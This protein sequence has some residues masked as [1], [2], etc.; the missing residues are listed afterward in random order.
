[1]RRAV[2]PPQGEGFL[3]RWSRLKREPEPAPQVVEPPAPAEPALPEGKTLEDLI[4]ELPKVEDLVPGQSVAAF[5]QPWVPT[6]LRNAALQRMWL[7]DPAIRDY[8]S[9]ALDYAYDYNTPG[10]APGFGQIE[11]TKD[12][13]REVA[14]LFDRALA[15]KE[16]A[17]DPQP[18]NDIV[19]QAEGP[20]H[21]ALQHE[22]AAAA[23]TDAPQTRNSAAE[24][25]QSVG[26]ADTAPA[27]AHNN[28]RFDKH[29]APS[30][31]R[32]GG[33]LPA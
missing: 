29:L 3:S 8:V 13:V 26:S 28:S 24:A 11:T 19:S 22:D 9:P 17:D 18:G 6:P 10:A 25:E 30:R 31:R 27:A 16:P 12:M 32:N 21:V 4:A 15:R 2:P 20:S 23:E 14:D 33:A 5:M 7:L 1:M